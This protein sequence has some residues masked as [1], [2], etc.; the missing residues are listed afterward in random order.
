MAHLNLVD[1][2]TLHVPGLPDHWRPS[3]AFLRA[4]SALLDGEMATA[5]SELS[6]TYASPQRRALPGQLVYNGNFYR[7]VPD[8]RRKMLGDLIAAEQLSGQQIQSLVAAGATDIEIV[9]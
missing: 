6:R 3:L 4:Q 1:F 5:V 9:E 7:T 2:G 8:A